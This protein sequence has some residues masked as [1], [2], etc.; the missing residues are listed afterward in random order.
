MSFIKLAQA[1]VRQVDNAILVIKPHPTEKRYQLLE[2]LKAWQVNDVIVT[3]NS[4]L[5]LLDLLTVSSVV[6]QTWSMTG[7]EAITFNLPLIIVNPLNKNY[8][9]VIPYISGYGAKEAKNQT[10]LMELLKIFTNKTHPQTKSQLLS[11]RHFAREYI[12]TPDGQVCQR[13][14]DLLVKAS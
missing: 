11:A 3:N 5:E 1:A 2:E 10:Q 8:D 7:L 14:S 4:Q 13:I 9:Q 12:K 6:V